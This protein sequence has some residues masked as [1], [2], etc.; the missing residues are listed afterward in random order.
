MK[1]QYILALLITLII[2]NACAVV[3]TQDL[4]DES[5][6]PDISNHCLEKK[7]KNTQDD[8]ERLDQHLNH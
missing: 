1:T 7:K 8:M 2:L 3:P 5:P 4:C 6:A